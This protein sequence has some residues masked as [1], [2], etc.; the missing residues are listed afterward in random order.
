MLLEYVIAMV[1]SVSAVAIAGI[2]HRFS[3]ERARQDN[4]S[5]VRQKHREWIADVDEMLARSD[6]QHGAVQP[7]IRR[8]PAPDQLK[9]IRVDT[10]R[11]DA[12]LAVLDGHLQLLP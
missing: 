12:Q 3:K 9:A 11:I 1:T 4:K 10:R 2:A 7:V 6:A 5:S 8:N